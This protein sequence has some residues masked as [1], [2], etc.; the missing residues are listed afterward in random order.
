[1]TTLT[2]FMIRGIIERTVTGMRRYSDDL[3]QGC[4]EVLV[5]FITQTKRRG[6]REAQ[7]TVKKVQLHYQIIFK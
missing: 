5:L 4:L 6:N 7:E 3:V 2:V 1:M